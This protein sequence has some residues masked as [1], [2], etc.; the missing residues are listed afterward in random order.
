MPGLSSERAPL[1]V[2]LITRDE[3]ANVADC[4]ASVAFAAECIV[5]D[6]GSSDGTPGIARSLGAHV[7]QASDWP[8]FGPQKNRALAQ[9]TQP[10]VLSI[11]AD[12]RVTPQLRD[13]ILRTIAQ[14]AASVAGW[15]MPRKSSFC[16]QYMAHSGW[17]PDRVTRLFR[18]GKGRFSDDLVHERVIV[19]GEVG[20]LRNDLLHATYPDLE[21]ML[22]KLDRYSS[23]SAQA[24]FERGERSSLAGAIVR[25]AWA[26]FRTY[27]LRL[28][29][30]DG[31]MGFVLAV[32]VAETT[33][34]KYLKLWIL[35]RRKAATGV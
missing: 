1:S 12:E 13:E 2:V 32:S 29:V 17:Y 23:A 14:D 19:D 6:S 7:T 31:R 25:G 16:G 20:H 26:F 18:R 15:D 27:V 30:L 5:V 24:L 34:Y 11:D 3:A 9:A 28:G 10:W 4:L 21:T 33:Y 35:G 22:A 8:G